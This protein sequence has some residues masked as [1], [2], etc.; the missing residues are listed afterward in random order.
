MSEPEPSGTEVTPPA[1]WGTAMPS[2][3]GLVLTAAAAVIAVAGLRSASNIVASLLLAIVIT[4]AVLPLG[5]A[6]LRRGW[7][8]WA[9]ALV[10]VVSAIMTLLVVVGGV[11]LSIAQLAA[12]LPQY[13]PR[14]QDLTSSLLDRLQRAGVDTGSAETALKNIDIG[15]VVSVLQ[16]VLS[17]VLS[18]LSALFFLG[19]LLFF[20][21]ADALGVS[22]RMQALR[23]AN[24]HV[25]QVL[26]D[27]VSG[28][29]RYL[30]VSALFGAIV[31]VFDVGAL[32]ALGI[33]LAFTWG[34]LSFLTNFIPNVGFVLGVI[35]PALLAL[36]EFGP[37]RMIAV[38][39]AYSVLNVVIQTFIQPRYVGDSV[40]L[41]ATTTFLALA[42][43]GFVLGPLGALLAIPATLLVRALF[44]D[45]RPAARWVNIIIGS[46]APAPVRPADATGRDDDGSS[47]ATGD[48]GSGSDG[49]AAASA[50]G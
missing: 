50:G 45:Y 30:L 16:S 14:V 43:W 6:A 4:V 46:G 38:L 29:Q 48:G 22:Q 13:A 32:Y 10:T 25:A 17:S 49:P 26:V 40:G 18:A 8:T 47:D 23:T 1:A 42:F 35:P 31:A 41:N 2:A 28:T 21:A 36:L 19:V 12:T 37:G 5:R 44:V 11:A 20:L 7:P 3:G 39:V 27:F 15:K 33:P 24:P 9:A 34:L